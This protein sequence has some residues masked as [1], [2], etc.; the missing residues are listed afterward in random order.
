MEDKHLYG[1]IWEDVYRESD[2]QPLWPGD[3][4]SGDC[5][6]AVGEPCVRVAIGTNYGIDRT[7]V[8]NSIEEAVAFVTHVPAW[9]NSFA[10]F[11][12][13]VD[14]MLAAA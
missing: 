11:E 5:W 8:F 3:K 7:R 4:P 6:P 13:D 10:P 1:A 9:R 12:E 14:L 2:F